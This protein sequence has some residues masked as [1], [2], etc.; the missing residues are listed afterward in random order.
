MRARFSTVNNERRAYKCALNYTT[1]ISRFERPWRKSSELDSIPV[2][3]GSIC[4]AG[5][6][7][8]DSAVCDFTVV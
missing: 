6:L 3:P 4:A 7:A 8:A 2:V 1:Y 5:R